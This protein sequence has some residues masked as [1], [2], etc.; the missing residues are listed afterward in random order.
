MY[1]F[2]INP[3][4]TFRHGKKNMEKGEKDSSE[5]SDRFS[6][7]YTKGAGDAGRIAAKVT[8]GSMPVH[9]VLIGG[10]GLFTRWYP[11]LKTGSMFC[12]LYSGR[13]RK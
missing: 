9:L 7:I 2:I 8:S 4:A 5:A 3:A 13:I 12:R 11:A 6:R 10:D 1:D